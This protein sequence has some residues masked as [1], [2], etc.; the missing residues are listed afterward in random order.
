MNREDVIRM[1]Q[2]CQLIGMR[3]HLDGIYQDALERFAALAFAAGAAHERE[4]CAK[5]CIQEAER[6]EKSHAAMLDGD[7]ADPLPY[8]TGKTVAATECAR[9]ISARGQA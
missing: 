2:E 9:M 1:A 4:E 6:V 3:P 5:V 7:D 8:M